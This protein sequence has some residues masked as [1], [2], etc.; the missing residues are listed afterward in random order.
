MYAQAAGRSRLHVQNRSSDSCSTQT[1]PSALFVGGPFDD[2]DGRGGPGGRWIVGRL[3]LPADAD[4]Y[5]A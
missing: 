5:E 2:D 1:E 3:F 4:A